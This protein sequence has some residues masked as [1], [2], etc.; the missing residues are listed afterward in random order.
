LPLKESM[1]FHRLQNFSPYSYYLG[2]RIMVGLQTKSQEW[3]I[4]MGHNQF[5][6]KKNTLIK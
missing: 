6:G 5:H 1:F 4:K 3:G 2:M